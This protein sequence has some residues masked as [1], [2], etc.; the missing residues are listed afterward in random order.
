MSAHRPSRITV[1]VDC[2]EVIFD[3]VILAALK[4]GRGV[5]AGEEV[6]VRRRHT[7][8]L[9]AG[10]GVCGGACGFVLAAQH[11]VCPSIVLVDSRSLRI[12]LAVVRLALWRRCARCRGRLDV[13]SAGLLCSVC[14]GQG[15]L[16][17]GAV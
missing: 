10:R 1:T 5:T 6:D 17:G 16:F 12:A 2:P 8:E 7:A 3:P 9:V 11:Q 13:I 4:A 14:T 15:D